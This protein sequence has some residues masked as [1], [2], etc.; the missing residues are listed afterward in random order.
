MSED[1]KSTGSIQDLLGYL[2]YLLERFDA[3]TRWALPAGSQS[4]GDD[5]AGPANFLGS[6]GNP[7]RP[8]TILDKL[9]AD[10]AL[11]V[12]SGLRSKAEAAALG[13]N[14]W[15]AGLDSDTKAF[16][17]DIAAELAAET[18]KI[19]SP[20]KTGSDGGSA[21][22]QPDY[23]KI[24]CDGDAMVLAR[25]AQSAYLE[26]SMDGFERRLRALSYER[27]LGRPDGLMANLASVGQV[28]GFHLGVKPPNE[29]GGA[30]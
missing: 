30:V 22:D 26:S 11:R 24:I 27:G 28:A 2:E 29:D 21:A 1:A 25:N 17:A 4:L 13:G 9:D 12:K 18:A 6:Q 8:T 7:T 14:F 20:V 23:A 3:K 15:D 19:G 16:C 5:P 10:S